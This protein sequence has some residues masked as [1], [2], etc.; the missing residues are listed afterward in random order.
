MQYRKT[1]PDNDNVSR[2]SS[3][4]LELLLMP[5]RAREIALQCG[6]EHIAGLLE[7]HARLC[8]RNLEASLLDK[9]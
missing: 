2:L 7:Q 9:G 5:L 1:T 8:E 4:A 6:S 3:N